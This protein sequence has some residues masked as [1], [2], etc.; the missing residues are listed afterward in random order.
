MTFLEFLLAAAWAG[1]VTTY[2][3]KRIAHRLLMAVV[4]VRAVYV[5]VVMLVLVVVL[6]VAVRAMDVGLLVHK[7]LH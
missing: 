7:Y 2:I 1:V 5:A 4:A 6:M 3:L